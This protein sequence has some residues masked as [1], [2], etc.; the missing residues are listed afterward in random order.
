M[1]VC[2]SYFGYE[3]YQIRCYGQEEMILKLNRRKDSELF[4]PQSYE[5]GGPLPFAAVRERVPRS[6]CPLPLLPS[7]VYPSRVD[8]CNRKSQ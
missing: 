8:H 5:G 2:T 3:E 1:L 7:Q 4:F 6:S